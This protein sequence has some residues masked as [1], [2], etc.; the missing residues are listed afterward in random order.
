MIKK[1]GVPFIGTTLSS[2][3]NKQQISSV[4]PEKP[5]SSIFLHRLYNQ[6]LPLI[7]LLLFM[8]ELP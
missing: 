5:N 4:V 3:G 2:T 7:D 8:D 6:F 1:W